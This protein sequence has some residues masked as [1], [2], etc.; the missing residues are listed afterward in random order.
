MKLYILDTIHNTAYNSCIQISRDTSWQTSTYTLMYISNYKLL[1]TLLNSPMYTFKYTSICTWLLS[2]SLLIFIFPSISNWTRLHPLSLLDNT[3]SS[4]LL[5][6][7]WIA[8]YCALSIW[9]TVW[10]QLLSQK[11]R[12]FKMCLSIYFQECISMLD[13]EMELD[14]DTMYQIEYGQ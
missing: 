13:T 9:R 3:G 8:L 5:H 2:L 14:A 12:C 1:F 7:L 11:Q 4:T 6:I 10:F